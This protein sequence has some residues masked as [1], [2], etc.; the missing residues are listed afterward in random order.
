M[1]SSILSTCSNHCPP[2]PVLITPVQAEEERKKRCCLGDPFHS[3]WGTA[4]L[5]G[6]M[7]SAPKDFSLPPY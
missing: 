5:Q 7:F 6:R 1:F 2:A 3:C 4:G